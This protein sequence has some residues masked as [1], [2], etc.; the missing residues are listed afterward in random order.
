MAIQLLPFQKVV[1]IPDV[2]QRHRR[3]ICGLAITSIVLVSL[4]V[5]LFTTTLFTTM[6]TRLNV[7]AFLFGMFGVPSMALVFILVLVSS[8]ISLRNTDRWSSTDVCC[9]LMRSQPACCTKSCGGNKHCCARVSRVHFAAS[10][11]TS[12]LCIYFG[13]LL[14]VGCNESPQRYY[15]YD[16]DYSDSPYR[17]HTTTP[18]TTTQAPAISEG[19][20]VLNMFDVP[21]LIL[22]ICLVATTA[23]SGWLLHK[24]EQEQPDI[25]VL[26]PNQMVVQDVPENTAMVLADVIGNACIEDKKSCDV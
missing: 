10:V 12:L 8:I 9:N 24:I 5:C 16:E 15:N 22:L 6:A 25:A 2:A 1:D 20:A 21:T 19:C 26:A 3:A 23:R 18:E 4:I 11:L 14:L 17:Y 13:V 7:T